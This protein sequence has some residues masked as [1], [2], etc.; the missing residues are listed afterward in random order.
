MAD[1]PKKPGETF[2][3]TPSGVEKKDLGQEPG[4]LGPGSG[5]AQT[6]LFHVERQSV[7]DG[8]E[9]GVLDNGI[10]YLTESGLARMCG[11]DRKVLNR[12]AVGWPE[13]KDK[14]RGRQIKSIL[15]KAGYDEP[16]L[17]LPSEMNGSP[18]NAYTE[19]VCLALLEYY[20]FE[21]DEKRPEAQRAFRALAKQTFRDFIYQ[22]VGYRPSRIALDSWQQFQDR[23]AIT[24]GK[25]PVG[26][27]GVFHELAG[28]I[29]PLIRAGVIVDDKTVPDIS[30]GKA[31]SQ[32]WEANDLGSRFGDRVRYDH[33]YPSYFP[34]AAS[35][36]Q[37]SFAYPDEAL[38]EFR[39]WMR[40]TYLKQKFP[41]Y[42]LG[43]VRQKSIA[44]T[45]ANKA[46]AAFGGDQILDTKKPK[47]SLN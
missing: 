11:I 4:V 25:A 22:A 37:R 34:Q 36:P 8:V 23:V 33:E 30:V 21:A 26:Y 17:F 42:L 43:K 10:P 27:W 20:A 40:E 14:P 3:P 6:P 31:W 47:G 41:A 39:H 29:V 45:A 28:M 24:D 15:D 2:G 16:A 32:H 19:P 12:L 35:N 9:M 13:E 5:L 18:I 1:T 7:I 44:F 46:I 38:A